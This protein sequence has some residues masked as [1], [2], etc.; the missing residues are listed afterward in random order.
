[1]HRSAS[2]DAIESKLWFKCKLLILFIFILTLNKQ[3]EK[4]IVDSKLSTPV[5]YNESKS[6]SKQLI[7]P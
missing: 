1:M 2:L 3:V 7:S 4:I 6:F 5:N